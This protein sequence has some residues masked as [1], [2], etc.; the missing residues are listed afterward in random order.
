MERQLKA[1]RLVCR[2]EF[3]LIEL[4]VVIAIIAI[5]AGMLLPALNRAREQARKVSCMN[6]LKQ[7]GVGLYSYA[8]D[9]KSWGPGYCLLFKDTT[10]WMR[11][12][13]QGSTATATG[14]LGYIPAVWPGYGAKVPP[15][16]LSCASR[17]EHEVGEGTCYTVNFQLR[18][19][20]YYTIN[21][22]TYGWMS[23]SENGL[24]RID[25]M[26]GK[27][28]PTNVVWFGDSWGYSNGNHSLRH[29]NGFNA[30]MVGMNVKHIKRSDVKGGTLSTRKGETFIAQGLY[31]PFV[32]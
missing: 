5:L 25:T 17:K 6:N 13:C 8:N 28:V 7:M 18:Q 2:K 15:K 4:L 21:Y 24:F 23:D 30:L 14:Y 19:G 1:K 31:T 16:L 11:Q 10:P 20:N 22:K 26:F 32:Y 3:T 9:F 27:S 29:D 12:L